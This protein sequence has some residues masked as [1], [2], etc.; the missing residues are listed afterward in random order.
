MGT[1][2]VLRTNYPRLFRELRR[3]IGFFGRVGDRT[4]FYA[5]GIAGMPHAAIRYRSEVIRLIAEISV[6]PAQAIE[7]I[8]VRLQLGNALGATGLREAA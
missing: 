6:R 8:T 7:V 2:T 1:V 4:M 5:K 3:P